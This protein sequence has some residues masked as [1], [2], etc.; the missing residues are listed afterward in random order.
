MKNSTFLG[1]ATISN[2][3][4]GLTGITCMM[5][6]LSGKCTTYAYWCTAR[7]TSTTSQ[8][9]TSI[10]LT[11]GYVLFIAWV[12]QN[13]HRRLPVALTRCFFGLEQWWQQEILRYGGSLFS[14]RGYAKP[15]SFA[16]I[17][18]E[19]LLSCVE[20]TP[21]VLSSSDV[22][23]EGSSP[24]L[25]RSLTASHIFLLPIVTMNLTANVVKF[26]C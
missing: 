23:S 8:P 10:T 2:H 7:N 12:E 24:L 20:L 16:V 14:R 18:R 17:A 11:V 6:S 26:S 9:S 4:K 25:E 13:M 15:R 5:L 1:I 19:L 3:S 21:H 22:K